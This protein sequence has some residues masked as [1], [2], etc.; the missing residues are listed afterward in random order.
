M[1]EP[2]GARHFP[3]AVV[4]KFLACL[5]STSV[6]AVHLGSVISMSQ[7]LAVAAF[8]PIS[9]LL[10]IAVSLYYFVLQPWAIAARTIILLLTIAYTRIIGTRRKGLPAKMATPPKLVEQIELKTK[11]CIT[12][13]TALDERTLRKC[14]PQ[15]QSPLYCKLPKELR[16]YILELSCT[17]SP[18]RAHP[19]DLNNYYY[20]PGHTARL[21]IH[22]SLLQ[23][24]RRIWLESSG[25]P[26]R[27]AEHAFWFQRGPYDRHGDQGWRANVKNERDRYKRFF[28]SL[29]TRN[30][31]NVTHIR[32]F[33]QMFQA[34]ELSLP[35]RMTELFERGL[36]MKGLKPKRFTLTIR[37]TDWYVW[38]SRASRRRTRSMLLRQSDLL[39]CVLGG[40]GK[41]AR[42]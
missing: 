25:L 33:M 7:D 23:T 32:M 36:I 31:P 34:Q 27:Q 21:E 6:G 3:P 10:I 26:M 18:N 4:S 14:H 11:R 5:L 37:S 15:S 2:R 19:Y 29:T 24:C 41:M 39:I 1:R 8:D 30:L 35:P 42:L 16:D 22:T 17:Q 12:I 9:I 40:V 28:S 38:P 13:E 20:R